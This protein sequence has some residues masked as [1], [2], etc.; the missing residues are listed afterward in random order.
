MIHPYR[1]NS[2]IIFFCLSAIFS[3]QPH[4]TC[5]ET[6]VDPWNLK[7]Y[8]NEGKTPPDDLIILMRFVSVAPEGSCWYNFINND[9]IPDIENLLNGMMKLKCYAGGV[10]GDEADTI[11]KMRMHQVH[12]IGVTNMGATIMVPELCVLELP[13]L[14]DYEPELHWNGKFTEIDYILEKIEPTLARLAEKHG[15]I[16][17]GMAESW[18]SFISSKTKIQT[19]ED[20]K[21]TKFWLWRG[22]RIRSE[23]TDAMGFGSLYSTDLFSVAQAFSTNRIDTTW[24]GY[25]AAI[26]LQW[27]PHLK[28]VTDQPIF[29]YESATCFLDKGM[30]DIVVAFA[31][32][33]GEK[34][35]IKDH[36]N[37]KYNLSKLLDDNLLKMRFIAR[38]E[39]AKARQALLNQGIEE[40]PIPADEIKKLQSRVEPLYWQLADEKY[41]KALLEEI[42][43]YREEYRK[44]KKEGKLTEEWIEKG[45]MPDGEPNNQWYHF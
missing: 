22:D 11:R 44:L 10:L 6:V 39:E 25:N 16:F 19:V 21:K 29:G 14:F 27:W 35:G 24:V 13:F 15:Y 1:L 17:G 8:L 33:W 5:A 37:L 26:L 45:I 43:K 28:Y 3:F 38:N 40:V 18:L 31:D 12:A 20:L 9:I 30:T 36:K 23:I 2:L 41:P 7:P 4:K 32:K 34:Y 42:I